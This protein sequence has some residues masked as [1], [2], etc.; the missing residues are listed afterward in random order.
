MLTLDLGHE[1]WK[2]PPSYGIMRCTDGSCCALGKA[3]I[4]LGISLEYPH[5]PYDEIEAVL[6]PVTAISAQIYRV[7]DRVNDETNQR[8]GHEE[9]C[10]MVVDLLKKAGKVTVI[11]EDSFPYALREGV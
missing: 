5:S 2:A 9:A 1:V 7:N 3:C 11:N 6:P 8:D 4:A 10:R